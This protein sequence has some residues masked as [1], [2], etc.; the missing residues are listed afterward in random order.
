MPPLYC[1]VAL[2]AVPIVPCGSDVVVIAS[3][4]KTIL[5]VNVAVTTCCGT[6]LSASC[7]VN[8]LL[9]VAVGVPL[10]T[11]ALESE[12]PAGNDPLATLHVT[13]GVPP[14]Y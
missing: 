1:S 5:I 7:T 14:V 13:A 3:V 11:P 6:L 10:I 12:R 2:Y 8:V 4:L 9:P